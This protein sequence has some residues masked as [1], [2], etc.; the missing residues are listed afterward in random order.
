MELVSRPGLRTHLDA[1]TL[2]AFAERCLRAGE[3]AAVFA[4]LAE[5]EICR[6]YLAAHSELHDFQWHKGQPQ[7][8]RLPR[9]WP[10]ARSLRTAAGLGSATAALWLL[11]FSHTRPPIVLTPS[12]IPVDDKSS[13]RPIKGPMVASGI[14]TS[15]RC[16]LR[17]A[18]SKVPTVAIRHFPAKVAPTIGTP[19]GGDELRN[20]A[21]G[22][23]LAARNW[24]RF[25]DEVTL[26][27]VAFSGQ[28][29]DRQGDLS[30]LSLNQI[31]LKTPFGDRR[32]KLEGERRFTL[33]P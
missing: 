15:G 25:L 10:L 28:P 6:Q 18:K 33:L 17:A 9:S 11:F 22:D 21:T 31:E 26:A 4:H 2:A 24:Q 27:T 23:R 30:A 13:A 1:D 5:C 16:S 14:K 32:I 20:L 7:N 3:E 12:R 8:R 29:T 19:W